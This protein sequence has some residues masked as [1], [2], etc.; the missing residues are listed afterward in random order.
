MITNIDQLNPNAKYSFADYLTWQFEQTVEL[1]KGKVLKMSPAPSTTH[2]RVL[3]KTAGQLDR[4]LAGKSCELFI[5]PFDVRLYDTKKSDHTNEIYTVVQPDLCIVCDKAKIDEY[6]CLGA[7]D[8]VVEILSPGNSKKEMRIKFDLYEEAGV[9]EYWIV[10]PAHQTIQLFVLTDNK[11]I[12]IR[13]YITDDLM[14]SG[15]FPE[16]T[17]NVNNLFE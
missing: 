7:P 1:I 11:F 15:I 8:L 17:I 12:F 10:D 6:G 3:R 9:R 16:L 4:F 14:L 2:Q 13:N 5:S